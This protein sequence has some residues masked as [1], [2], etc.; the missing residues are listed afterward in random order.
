MAIQETHLDDDLIHSIGQ[1]FGK[2]LDTINSQIPTN[3][4]TLAGIAFVINKNLIEPKELE[5]KELIE[6]HALV[7]KFK[8]HENDEIVLINIYAPNNRTRHPKFWEKIDIE[9]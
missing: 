7:I 2:R 3:P 6:G 4:Q 9:R 8:W 5:K 1:C